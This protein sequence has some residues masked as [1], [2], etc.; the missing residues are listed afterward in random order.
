MYDIIHSIFGIA[1]ALFTC[2]NILKLY[3]DNKVKGVSIIFV[4]FLCVFNSWN[5]FY[6]FSLNQTFAAISGVLVLIVNS[7]WFGQMLYYLRKES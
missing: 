3:K 7:I 6:L 5:I 4:I 2:F 1:I